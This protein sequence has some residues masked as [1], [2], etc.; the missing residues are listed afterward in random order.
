MARPFRLSGIEGARALLIERRCIQLDPLDPMGT[1]ADLVAMARVDGLKKGEI[2]S[3]LLPGHGFE[4]FAKERCLLPPS[5]FPYYRDQA[6]QTPWWRMGDREKRL[7]PELIEQVRLEVA[8]RGPITGAD[9]TDHGS[10]EPLNWHGWKST[11][12]ATQMALQVL[13]RRC[14]VVVCGRTS[15]GKLYDVPERALPEVA[16]AA[17]GDFARWAV[18]ER[19]E[20]AGLLSRSDGPQWSMLYDIRRSPLPDALVAEGLLREVVIRGSRRRYLAPANWRDRPVDQPDDRM[21]IVGPL[22]PMIGDRKLTQQAFDFEYLW[23]VYKPAAKRRWGWYV[24]PLLHAGR[25][26]GRVEARVRQNRLEVD[27]LWGERIPRGPLK[28]ALR[29]HARGLGAE[30]VV[31]EGAEI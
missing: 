15:A 18:L 4:H 19:V 22:D 31:L 23:E 20:A 7:P 24:C 9:I 14:R 3:A 30:S 25:L 29:R 1:N 6:V 13:W 27:N 8:R 12:R 11:N 28:A 26:V 21:R 16:A 17:S 10:V 2:Y 5:A